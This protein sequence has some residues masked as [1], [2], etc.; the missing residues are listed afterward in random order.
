MSSGRERLHPGTAVCPSQG[1][2]ADKGLK[3]NAKKETFIFFVSL[4]LT[5]PEDNI[6]FVYIYI[7]NI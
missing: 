4:V 2:N 6:K 1:Q 5:V 3:L 7:V